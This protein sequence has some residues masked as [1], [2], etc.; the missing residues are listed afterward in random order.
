MH[1]TGCCLCCSQV[2]STTTLL[3]HRVLFSRVEKKVWCLKFYQ[4]YAV[5]GVGLYNVGPTPKVL[6][7]FKHVCSLQTT[8]SVYTRKSTWI[9]VGLADE[10]GNDTHVQRLHESKHGYDYCSST[11]V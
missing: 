8:R 9:Q 10:Q 11:G 3:T 2:T 6:A 7:Y 4:T 1:T 5:D